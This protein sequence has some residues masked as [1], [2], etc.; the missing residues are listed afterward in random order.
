MASVPDGKHYLIERIESRRN[1]T[2]IQLGALLAAGVCITAAAMLQNPINQQRRELGLVSNSN[3]YAGLPPKYAWVSA[4]GGTFRGLAA[5]FLWTRLETLK[6]EGKYY[7]AHQLA[8]W[9]CTVQPR[10]PAVWEFQAWNMAYN[11][12]VGTKTP[13]ERWQWVYNG[14]RLLRDEGIPNNEGFVPLYHELAW[15]WFHKVGDMLDDFHRTYKR[16]WASRMQTLLGEPPTAVSD[17]ELIDWFKPVAEAPETLKELLAQQPEVQGLID[18]LDAADVDVSVGTNADRITHPL[19]NAFFVPYTKWLMKSQNAYLRSPSRE[20]D[21]EQPPFIRAL[22]DAKAEQRD[23]LVA[24]L[25]AKVLREQYKMD[26]KFMLEIT[27]KLGMDKPLPLDWRTPWAHAIYWGF[28]GSEHGDERQ[29]QHS[30]NKIRLDRIVLFSL[31]KLA[32]T[33]RFILRLDPDDPFNSSLAMMPNVRFIEALHRK[34]IEL[35]PR[36][37]DDDEDVENRTAEIL[38]SGHVNNLES[39]IVA[40]YHSGRQEKARE[41]LAYLARYYKKPRTGETN[42]QYLKSLHDFVRSQYRDMADSLFQIIKL[43]DSLLTG[44]YIALSQ[45]FADQY[46]TSVAEAKYL[47]DK[48]QT[49]RTDDIQGRRALPPFEQVRAASLAGFVLDSGYD[50]VVRSRVWN[51]EQVQIRQYAYDGISRGLRAE[52]AEEGFAFRRAFPEPEGM[53]QFRKDHPTLL[54]PEDVAEQTLKEAREKAKA[55]EP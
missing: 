24:Y 42:P 47:F 4:A 45:G 3:I 7:E 27:G 25:R 55:Q 34:Y 18:A 15:I 14:I 54:R 35:G 1:A 53:E 40:L 8:E 50:M 38:R 44:G 33:G 6:Q 46:H 49:D 52:C 28:Y 21:A 16:V 17:A 39:A 13:H 22:E 29:A 11:I 20:P 32:N 26:P 30:F 41:Y 2:L 12:S 19:E 23:A 37:A 48:Y 31:A 9:I 36:Y 5:D 10:V 51:H 43:M